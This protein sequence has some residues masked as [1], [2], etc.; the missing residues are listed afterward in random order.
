MSQRCSYKWHRSLDSAQSSARE[1]FFQKIHSRGKLSKYYTSR[2]LYIP[3]YPTNS[4][5]FG[6]KLAQ[7]RRFLQHYYRDTFIESHR[8]PKDL[9]QISYGGPETCSIEKK[10]G[11]SS[12]FFKKTCII[13]LFVVPLQPPRL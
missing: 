7:C 5:I 11:H 2:V 1:N 10:N 12:S 8:K 3:L 6:T 9:P 13:D 4:Q